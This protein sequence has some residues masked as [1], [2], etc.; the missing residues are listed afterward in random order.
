MK[1]IIITFALILASVLTYACTGG[2]QQKGQT[3]GKEAPAEGSV[4]VMNK[5]MFIK[6]VFDYEKSK[7]WKYKGDKPAIIDLYADWCGPCRM[8][9][10]IMKE[11]AK[12]YAG[13]IVIYKV[14]VDK[15]KELAA[16]FNATSI[17]LLVFIPMNGEPQLF[18]GAAD[19][20]T[21]K[22]AIDE[23]LLKSE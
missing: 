11:L 10:P 21:Y 15:E 9:A 22:K 17:P 7:E 14:N 4:I 5:D 16:L 13:K 1:K 12:E 3:E 20:A 2:T 23:F 8:T 19:K 6:N 18:R